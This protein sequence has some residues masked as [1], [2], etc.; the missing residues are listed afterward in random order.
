MAK[1]QHAKLSQKDLIKMAKKKCG[2]GPSFKGTG[3][4][5]AE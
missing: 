4:I 3:G 2:L 5:L 1:M